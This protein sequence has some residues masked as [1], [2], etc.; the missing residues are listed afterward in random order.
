[1]LQN[2]NRIRTLIAGL[3]AIL[4]TVVAV[5]G[6]AWASASGTIKG[7]VLDESELPIPGALVTLTS[8][9]LI[10]GGRQYTSDSDGNFVFAELPP[11]GY[12]LEVDK[13]GFG[14]VTKTGVVVAVGR[15]TN[16]QITMK[17][18]G[19]VVVIEEKRK[20]VDTESAGNKTTFSKDYLAKVPS[21]RSY[22]DVIGQAAQVVDNGSGNPNAAGAS[23]QENTWTLDGVNVSDPVTG[24]FS[25]NF[26]F[27]AIEEI[28]V[29]TGG[30]D[31]EFGESLGGLF[32]IVTKSGGNTLEILTNA[33]YTNGNWSPKLD[34]RYAA[35][36]TQLNFT[37]FDSNSQSGTVGLTISGPVV[38]DR[39]WFIG[40]YQYSRS[41]FTNV[42][43]RT[44][45]DYDAHYFFGK[46]TMQPVSAHR[47]T[48]SLPMDPTTVD[49][50][51]Q[52][53]R[54]T[55][56]EAQGRQMQGGY[57]VTGKWNWFLNEDANLE[58][59]AA[60]QKSFIELSGVPCSHDKELAYNPCEADEAENSIDYDTPGRLGSYGAFNRD[61]FYQFQFDDRWRGSL[62]TKFS[63]LNVDFLGKHDFK[64]GVDAD[65]QSW[66]WVTGFTGNMLFVDLYENSYD[67]QTLKNWYWY[68]FA[69][70][71][72]YAAD[73]Y[74]AA[75]F[76]QDVYKPVDNLTFRY[77][78]R[79]DRGVVRNDQAQNIVDVGVFG[80][81]IYSV[82]DPWG[83][84]KTAISAGYG[85]F[86]DVGRLDIG[87]SLKRSGT[88]Q[89]I[90][91]DGTLDGSNNSAGSTYASYPTDNTVTFNEDLSAPH[92]D[93]FTASVQR[94]IVADVR[95]KVSFTGKF[96]RN[97][98]TFDE[99]N[100]VYDSDGYGFIGV[101]NGY[102][103][104][105]DYYRLRTPGLARRDYYGVDVELL[106]I[107]SK[108]WFAMGTYSYV[109]SRGT[110]QNALGSNLSNPSQVELWYGDLGTDVTHQ[111]KL[112][113][114]W[115][116]PNDPWTTTVGMA[117][118]GFSGY[119]Q[120]RYYW[121]AAD[122]SQAGGTYGLLKE[123]RGEYADTNP[124]WTLD[125]QVKQEIV[126]PKGKLNVR[127]DLA[128]VTD[129]HY[130]LA[131]SS[132]YISAQ[133]RYVITSHQGGISGTLAVGYEY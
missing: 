128:N 66:D 29:T 122:L 22:Q 61:N 106:K 67:P 73:G 92:S 6:P 109:S 21:G 101:S 85:R 44:P 15:T 133:N 45:L 127:L 118:Q 14:K 86:N 57:V 68:E 80:P 50:I 91:Y 3:A 108:R 51:D 64:A 119:P 54:Y 30:F 27:D 90:V 43:I 13:Q 16:V 58:T 35:D 88:G 112:A 123:P 53:D 117:S 28:T 47:I 7:L 102:T 24:T 71:S 81:R 100:L 107:D 63:V 126:V 10:G 70:Y 115:E 33:Q 32:S 49:N 131:V 26:N 41:L 34:A 125:L 31:P 8:D 56:P 1:M 94:E 96:T 105:Q 36:G 38:R 99:T 103:D 4:L 46:L 116:I 76:I 25:T 39:I 69:G 98:Y 42:G 2:F 114:Y 18:G 48:L 40:S 23:Y 19:E 104:F 83:D 52:G 75:A 129:N 65:Y 77:G 95:A 87:E 93:E 121:Q 82:W 79:Y 74:S 113:A 59:T 130:T 78:L 89:K 9:K 72:R 97:I 84:E 62:G 132:G 20:V 11:G 60:L 110:T 37:G 12:K 5:S 124:F 120:S 17:Y 55:L 111:L